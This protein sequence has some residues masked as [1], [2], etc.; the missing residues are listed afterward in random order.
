MATE[1]LRPD[2]T[3][4]STERSGTQQAADAARDLGQTVR[5]QAG[6]GKDQALGTAHDLT[7]SARQQAE[8]GKEQAADRLEHVSEAVRDA[9]HQMQGQEAWLAGLVERGADEMARLAETLRTNDLRSLLHHAEDLARRQ[10]M[11]A[12]GAAFAAGF[13]AVRAAKV[14]VAEAMHGPSGHAMPS[15]SA[16]P[17]PGSATS[18]GSG[19]GSAAGTTATG[20]G[21]AT[22]PTMQATAARD[23]AGRTGR[24]L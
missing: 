24:E 12:A 16:S 14:G 4:T 22:P 8:T 3:G 2:R 19:N 11:L 15:T 21:M 5:Q 9:A 1:P 17:R 20:A 10:P 18:N 13:A 6:A 23:P 7:D